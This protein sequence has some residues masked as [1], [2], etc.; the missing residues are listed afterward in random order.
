M[1]GLIA[2]FNNWRCP[3][4]DHLQGNFWLRGTVFSIGSDKSYTLCPNCGSKIRLER[5][6]SLFTLFAVFAGCVWVYPYFLARLIFAY[7]PGGINS[8]FAAML[9]WWALYLVG[10]Y[11][12]LRL[13]AREFFFVV[14]L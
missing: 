1:T 11:I 3:E 9:L 14:K 6:V 12:L 13:F 8:V 7:A 4:C 10:L 2:K 5:T